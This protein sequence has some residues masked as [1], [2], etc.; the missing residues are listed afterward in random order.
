[1]YNYKIIRMNGYVNKSDEHL[2][3]VMVRRRVLRNCSIRCSLKRSI[4]LLKMDRF[5]YGS[6]KIRDNALLF[7]K[8]RDY[9][10]FE[11]C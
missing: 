7:L 9:L 5:T 11:Q 6:C 10:H 4:E 1:M 8:G 3:N 2:I